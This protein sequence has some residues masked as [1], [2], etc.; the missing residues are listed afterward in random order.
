[1]DKPW[2]ISPKVI[3]NNHTALIKDYYYG[4]VE[5]VFGHFDGT[6]SRLVQKNKTN[7]PISSNSESRRL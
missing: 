3:V 7:H 4:K 2:E 6:V 5:D 1:M